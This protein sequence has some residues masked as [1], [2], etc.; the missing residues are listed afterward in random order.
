M[1]NWRNTHGSDRSL[2]DLDEKVEK[3]LLEKAAEAAAAGNLEVVKEISSLF[4]ETPAQ[5]PPG[6]P[7]D[8]VTPHEKKLDLWRSCVTAFM[9]LVLFAVVGAA[10]FTSRVS[11]ADTPYVS[12]LSGL[13]G[14]A[15]GW[16][17][18]N[19]SSSNKKSRKEDE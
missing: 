6:Q 13:A 7:V 4:S 10:L 8:N 19:S 16:M 17:F 1:S 12:L 14:I 9:V 3:A 2:R 18:A 11:S 5:S 15:L